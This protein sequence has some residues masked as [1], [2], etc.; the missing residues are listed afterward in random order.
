MTQN[1]SAQRSKPSKSIQDPFFIQYSDSNIASLDNLVSLFHLLYYNNKWNCLCVRTVTSSNS[2]M[3]LF[4]TS[5]TVICKWMIA[6]L[7]LYR[8]ISIRD[9]IKTAR[10]TPDSY[11][12]QLEEENHYA[13]M[14]GRWQTELEKI[15][16]KVYWYS[17]TKAASQSLILC[18]DAI[19]RQTYH[20]SIQNWEFCRLAI[21]A[22]AFDHHGWIIT[23]FH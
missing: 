20:L 15:Y 8:S 21:S 5:I 9:W 11:T 16:G 17:G 22:K 23:K 14:Y 2:M 13:M 10:H 3:L 6:V 18:C 19:S 7:C 4:I 1:C 12:L